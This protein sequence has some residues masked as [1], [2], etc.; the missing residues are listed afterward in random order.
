MAYI[1]NPYISNAVYDP[2]T[3]SVSIISPIISDV[4]DI[5]NSPLYKQPTITINPSTPQPADSTSK[6]LP[7][8]NLGYS[9]PMV[10][11]YENLNADPNLQSRMTKYFY[12]K[13]LDKWLYDEI[14][15]VLNYLTSKNDKIDVLSNLNEY[16]SSTV[17]KDSD[18][19]VKKKI[20]FIENY[21]LT[22]SAMNGILSEIT[23]SNGIQWVELPKNEY[24][25]K[26]FI[27]KYLVRKLKKGD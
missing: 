13:V 17:D 5:Y 14:D 20:E 4:I 19:I 23:E 24:I 18:I 10:G 3:S 1:F 12:F 26:S 15:D 25:V 6:Y 27:K 16:K 8:V 7:S 11:F 22:K 21:F 9:A 2:A